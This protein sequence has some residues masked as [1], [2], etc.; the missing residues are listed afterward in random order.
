MPRINFPNNSKN[1]Q[2]LR[3]IVVSLVVA[4]LGTYLLSGSH[5]A[6]PYASVTATSGSLNGGA[7]SQT[8]AGAS[9]G[10][11]VLFSQALPMDGLVALALTNPGTPFD[12][13]SF[14]N[15]PIPNNAPLN[16]NNA[17]YISE[18]ANQLCYGT[19]GQT[20]GACTT[21]NVSNGVLNSS[22][23]SAPLYVVPANQPLVPVAT[24]CGSGVI[25]DN[26]SDSS[27][28]STGWTTNTTSAT[29]VTGNTS[30]LTTNQF[31]PIP[32]TQY[33]V[34]YTFSGNPA[35]GSTVA[36]TLGG[37]TV[38]SYT[39]S[40]SQDNFTDTK[41]I[42]TAAGISG[43]GL[44]TFTP[45]ATFDGTISAVSVLPY[46]AGLS[47]AVTGG[48]PIPVDAHGAGETNVPD[49][50][51]DKEI[52]IYQ[53]ST[54][55]E[56]E[57][58][59]FQ[60]YNSS[61]NWGACWGGVINNVSTSNGIFPN[62]TGAT[63][64]SLPLLGGVPRIEEFQAGHIDHVMN[65]TLI[66]RLSPSTVPANTPSAT[67]GISWP[68]TRS[69]GGD[70]DPLAIPEGLRFRLNPSL[71]LTAYAQTHPLT[72]VAMTIA[73]AAQ[74]YGFVVDDGGGTVAIRIGD[75]TTY[76]T[77]G[78]PNPYTSGPGVGGAGNK[79]IFNGTGASS[80]IMQ[81][82]PWDQLEAL[83]YNYGEPGP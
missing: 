20:T 28:T 33:Q 51:T 31:E 80:V 49:T 17:A 63:A 68:A 15:T 46:K 44:L 1:K 77:A 18:I 34:T 78:L 23:W 70:T 53:P 13:T 35:S 60:K 22:N 76:T 10:N 67:N 38:G 56:W 58:W 61:G 5:A 43:Q 45:S 82:F 3:A 32:T 7:A 4:T 83:P 12:P 16:P 27:W 74:K 26:M 79:G 59:Q 14:W 48:V 29:H 36:V 19:T 30:A 64:T 37:V 25:D 62:N 55:K 52:Q 40:S 11:C 41:V 9:A 47:A 50:D 21:P 75:P 81:N 6:S 42:R 71:D 65:L 24:Y 2:Q 73:V 72:P 57:F 39:F 69:D 8:C 66:D 54:N